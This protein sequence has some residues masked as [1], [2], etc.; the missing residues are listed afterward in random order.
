MTFFLPLVKHQRNGEHF[1]VSNTYYISF[2]SL[3]F[4]IIALKTPF[5]KGFG[6]IYYFLVKPNSTVG[7][8][9]ST[10]INNQSLNSRAVV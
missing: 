1:R 9:L 10:K 2:L 4:K 7:I 8:V 3:L 6:K 5:K